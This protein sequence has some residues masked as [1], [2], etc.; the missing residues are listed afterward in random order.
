MPRNHRLTRLDFARI[1]RS[2]GKRIHGK[3]FSLL[4][5]PLRGEAAKF[6]C[7][8]SKKFSPKAVV[9]N[10]IERQAREAARPLMKKAPT[11]IA[12]VLYP[13]READGAAFSAIR[14]DIENLLSQ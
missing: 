5:V 11:G 4:V 2:K 3:Y 12:L 9:R 6:A 10:R 13:K 7:V 14:A 1:E 8:V